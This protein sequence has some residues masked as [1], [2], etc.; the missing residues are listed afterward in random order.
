MIHILEENSS[1]L[2]TKVL[3]LDIAEGQV[4]QILFSLK[5]TIQ[6]FHLVVPGGWAADLGQR[7][8][9]GS[10]LGCAWRHLVYQIGS[11]RGQKL[12]LLPFQ[13]PGLSKACNLSFE[14]LSSCALAPGF[15]QRDFKAKKLREL[16]SGNRK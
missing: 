4:V 14:N 9:S 7:S 8:Q 3:G 5:C 2:T 11:N 16:Q 15:D 6:I 10:W 1:D 12:C 13:V